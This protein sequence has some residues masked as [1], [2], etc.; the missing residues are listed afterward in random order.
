MDTNKGEPF[1]AKLKNEAPHPANRSITKLQ[2]LKWTGRP[3]AYKFTRAIR[4]R[5]PEACRVAGCEEPAYY[6]PYL[7]KE[8]DNGYMTGSTGVDQNCPFLCY[9]HGLEDELCWESEGEGQYT[10]TG[11]GSASYVINRRVLPY[12][13]TPADVA[14]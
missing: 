6:M 14:A 11:A 1:D 2:D 10:D 4:L 12:P 13:A 5:A 9:E 8:Y 3:P 7:F